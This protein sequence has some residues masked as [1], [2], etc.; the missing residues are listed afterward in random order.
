MASQEKP[1]AP[2]APSVTVGQVPAP[3]REESASAADV[4]A[5]LVRTAK[6]VRMYLPNNPM[7]VKFLEE[8]H[9]KLALHL[10]RFGSYRLEVE[11][12][13]LRYQGREVYQNA[14]Q[15]DNIA[16]RLHSDGIR[17]LQFAPGVTK[18]ELATF[19]DIAGFERPNRSE[20]DDVVTQLWGADLPAVSWLLEEDLIS[21][22]ALEVENEAVASQQEALSEIFEA[23]AV[24]RPHPHQ[25]I[26]K[27]LLML[28]S[29]ET[30]WLQKTMLTDGQG[31][32]VDDVLTIVAAS[33]A[34][35]RDQENFEASARVAAVLVADLF[36]AR[37]T[38]HAL[39]L[40]RFLGQLVEL[41]SLP[42]ERREM[43]AETLAGVLSE[44]VLQALQEIV[45]GS[46]ALSREELRELL[47][48]LGL[49]SMGQMCELLGRVEK[50]KMRK[51]VVEVLIELG[52]QHPEVFT[53]FLSDQR[54][55]LVR[56]VVMV[57]SLI[58][59]PA[60]LQMIAGL[61]SHKEA[62]VRKEVLGFLAQSP[63]PKAR[64][65]LIKFLRDESSS[66]RT[67][68][69]RVIAQ[70]RLSFALK[71]LLA[72]ASS[73]ELKHR[74]MEE[75]IALFETLG[76]LGSVQVIP[77]F[78]EMLSKKGWFK[79]S[80]PRET[81]QCVVAGLL[82]VR[83]VSA[84]AL[85]EDLRNQGGELRDVIDRAQAEGPQSGGT[86]A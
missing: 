76:E 85:L 19:L 57:L 51:V 58:D 23:L 82:K 24:Q 52:G 33:L 30:A 64:P 65:Y 37:Q 18:E 21:I 67:R 35:V 86:A 60:A 11:A 43:V 31:D 77:V 68:A 47:L 69:L 14:E 49:R 39:R 13:V 6:G 54:W 2:L 61:I 62:R 48:V 50:L 42:A 66:L 3:L 56:N 5:A 36:R 9:E 78:Q 32:P 46:E 28:S 8:L 22:D 40:V 41:G 79:R 63:D 38:R 84:R 17:V 10:E 53:P 81:A 34:G 75:K 55:Y 70:Q 4:M 83:H 71:P 45:N 44:E 80:V 25:V 27:H 15:R 16:L 73:D 1:Q 74:G 29:A 20:D 26:P 12:F 72:L 59:S 7:L